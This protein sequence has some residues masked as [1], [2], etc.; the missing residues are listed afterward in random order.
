MD[1]QP[2]FVGTENSRFR[3]VGSD[4]FLP[5]LEPKPGEPVVE[6][7]WT[8]KRW[9]TVRQLLSEM[10]HLRTKWYE[11]LEEDRGYRKKKEDYVIGD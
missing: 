2:F 5:A 11:H 1:N 7:Q 4:G 10:K 9:D 8:G 6:I 3:G